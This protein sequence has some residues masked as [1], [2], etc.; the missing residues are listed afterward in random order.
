MPQDIDHFRY[1][2]TAEAEGYL[3][4]GSP[5]VQVFNAVPADGITLA[6][7]KVGGFGPVLVMPGC[8]G[9]LHRNAVRCG[10]LHCMP[11]CLLAVPATRRCACSALPAARRNA[12]SSLPAAR[13]CACSALPAALS[14]GA[15]GPAVD[16]AL[17]CVHLLAE[18]DLP[19][20][21]SGLP[22]VVQKQLGAAGDVGFK[23]AMQQKWVAIDKSGGEVG[24]DSDCCSSREFVGHSNN[25]VQKGSPVAAVQDAS[26]WRCLRLP[27]AP[28]P[29][30]LR[31]MCRLAIC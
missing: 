26:A 10:A 22:A 25:H 16:S 30:L 27:T 15:A 31:C 12:C 23:Q 1:K 2:L 21:V 17:P 24:Q 28:L 3:G 18:S 9:M 8:A 20:R 7:L 6:D 4:V 11:A 14:L 5:E 19:P 13:R 29:R